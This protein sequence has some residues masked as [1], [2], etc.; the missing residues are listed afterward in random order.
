MRHEDFV[1]CTRCGRRPSVLNDYHNGWEYSHCCS[2]NELTER[3]GFATL[4]DAVKDWNDFM[5]GELC[6]QKSGS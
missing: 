5:T 1:P 6:H 3:Y 4:Q 2:S